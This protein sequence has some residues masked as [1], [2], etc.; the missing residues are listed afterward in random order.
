MDEI[1]NNDLL[2]EHHKINGFPL[3]RAYCENNSETLETILQDLNGLFSAVGAE[4]TIQNCVLT[5]D[6]NEEK[7]TSVTKRK[8]G[9][10]SKRMNKQFEEI[11]AY[12][13]THTAMET[14]EWLG[15]TKQTYYRR[16][17]ELKE[18]AGIC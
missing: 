17:K 11:M 13:E 3:E 10:K 15:L 4:I 12:R 2:P 5:I 18:E 9:R 8:A 16:I 7:F 1:V 6:V 14:A